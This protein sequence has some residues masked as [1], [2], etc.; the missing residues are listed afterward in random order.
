MLL[1]AVT[2][3]SLL[4]HYSLPCLWAFALAGPSSWNF[5]PSANLSPL[6]RR[7]LPESAALTAPWLYPDQPSPSDLPLPRAGPTLCFGALV[8]AGVQHVVL[9]GQCTLSEWRN[10]P[11]RPAV[12]SGGWQPAV[13][14]RG[15]GRTLL[16]SLHSPSVSYCSVLGRWFS[17][18]LSDFNSKRNSSVKAAQRWLGPWESREGPQRWPCR[19]VTWSCPPV[20]AP[21]PPPAAA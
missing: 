3:P 15:C 1:H 8:P 14:E 10:E 21:L 6:S 17:R 19:S 12:P 9:P 7:P 13:T 5:L 20:H 4:T 2:S 11:T 18:V 16:C